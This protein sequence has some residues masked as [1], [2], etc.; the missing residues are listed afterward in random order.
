MNTVAP[1]IRS[2]SGPRKM[3]VIRYIEVA[4]KRGSTVYL[5]RTPNPNPINFSIPFR[6]LNPCPS[7]S[8]LDS[9]IYITANP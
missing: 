5:I 9:I 8:I 3:A 2:P 1:E 6:I 4:V 7:M